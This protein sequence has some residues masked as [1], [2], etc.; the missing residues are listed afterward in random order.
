MDRKG[1]KKI[2]V[3]CGWIEEPGIS[4]EQLSN[5]YIRWCT[6]TYGTNKSDRCKL[7]CGTCTCKRDDDKLRFQVYTDNNGGIAQVPCSWIN[8]EAID[9][10]QLKNR[11]QNHCISKPWRGRK[12][13]ATCEQAVSRLNVTPSPTPSFKAFQTKEELQAAVNS[14]CSNPNDWAPGNLGYA[15]YG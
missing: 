9:E 6:D 15:K 5:R 10:R 7:S 2:P 13:C 12:C 11:I 8:E 3:K 14:Y 1:G 4:K